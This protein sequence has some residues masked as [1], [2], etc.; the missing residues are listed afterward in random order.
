M[1]GLLLV[2]PTL[3]LLYTKEGVGYICLPLEGIIVLGKM[4]RFT[5][6]KNLVVH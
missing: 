4:K 2:R 3:F 1:T 5:S 6:G